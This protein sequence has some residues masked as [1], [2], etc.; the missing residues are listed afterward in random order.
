MLNLPL[1][2]FKCKMYSDAISKHVSIYKCKKSKR[3]ISPNYTAK[4]FWTHTSTCIAFSCNSY[5]SGA[6]WWL[7]EELQEDW[8]ATRCRGQRGAHEANNQKYILMNKLTYW[9]V[10]E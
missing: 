6:F 4:T 9:K 2:K 5:C 8:K 10:R 1:L 3:T 7:K